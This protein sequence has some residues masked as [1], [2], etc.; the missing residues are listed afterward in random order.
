M[1]KLPIWKDNWK[2]FEKKNIVVA[3][4]ILDAKNKKVYPADV[5][6]KIQSVKNKLFY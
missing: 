6:N 4:N 3:L 5:L 2:K 1:N